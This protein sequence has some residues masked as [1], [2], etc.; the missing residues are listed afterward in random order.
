LLPLAPSS[1]AKVR[2]RGA[3]SECLNTQSLQ[4]IMSKGD[5]CTMRGGSEGENQSSS[6]ISASLRL[7][8]S[9]P[10]LF[11]NAGELIS[12]FRRSDGMTAA[13]SVNTTS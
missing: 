4:R 11:N 6:S 2:A 9:C 12:K 3:C 5:S 13:I 10:L 8:C 7:Q 1:A